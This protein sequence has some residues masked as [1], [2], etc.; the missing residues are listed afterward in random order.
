MS[1]KICESIQR[2][3]DGL[4]HLSIHRGGEGW[5]E[6]EKDLPRSAPSAAAMASWS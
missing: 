1:S 4:S 3:K 5:S 2:I 6:V